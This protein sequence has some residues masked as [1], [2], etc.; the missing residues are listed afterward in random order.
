MS[1][2]H[3]GGRQISPSAALDDVVDVDDMLDMQCLRRAA[4]ARISTCLTRQIALHITR[5]GSRPAVRDVPRSSNGSTPCGPTNAAPTRRPPTALALRTGICRRRQWRRRRDRAGAARDLARAPAPASSRRSRV[6]S[7]SVRRRRWRSAARSSFKHQSAPHRLD[8]L[9]PRCGRTQQRAHAECDGRR[10][11]QKQAHASQHDQRRENEEER[12]PRPQPPWP[13]VRAIVV[14]EGDDP[15][16]CRAA[17][18]D[19]QER[20]ETAHL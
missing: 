5:E 14:A 16:F 17:A 1:T 9:R 3:R 10:F 6:R 15:R 20:T 7:Q 18:H 19:R 12:R 11:R 8:G 13:V 2:T 4:H